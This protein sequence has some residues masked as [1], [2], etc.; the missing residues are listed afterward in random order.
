MF[1]I[2][3]FLYFDNSLELTYFYFPTTN[4]QQPTTNNQQ[5][6]TNNQQQQSYI[7]A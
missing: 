4:N 1:S 7:L 2:Q 5:P 6:T 3:I